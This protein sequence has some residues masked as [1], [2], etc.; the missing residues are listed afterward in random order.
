MQEKT[1]KIDLN[2]IEV[3]TFMFSN[4]N[5]VKRNRN[6]GTKKAGYK[7]QSEFRIPFQN[8]MPFYE[9]I[10]KQDCCQKVVNGKVYYFIIEK[11][12]PDYTY[13]CS[14]DE[15]CEVL[16]H[17]PVDDLEGL[18]LIILRQPKKKEEIFSLCWG[19]LIYKFEYNGKLQPA[20]ILEA[21][22]LSKDTVIKKSE[23]SLFF[24][25]ELQILQTEGH[26]IIDENHNIIIK[27]NFQ[28]AR[29]TQLFRT[30]PH[31]IGHY[32]FCKSGNR[33]NNYEEKESYANGYAEKIRASLQAVEM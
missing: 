26:E 32:V 22:N 6:I 2:R 13:T 17:C 12:K 18:G 19:R 14:V 27:R 25:K 10:E 31:E 23:M 33:I 4:R 15:I 21:I 20:I 29:N 11:L 7:K 24:K 3:Y 5:P 8:N 1:G 9:N 16:S 28:A 30:L